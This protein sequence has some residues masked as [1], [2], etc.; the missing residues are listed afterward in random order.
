MFLTVSNKLIPLST[1]M[2]QTYPFVFEFARLLS[3][4]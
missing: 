1:E 4:L 3:D 2:E